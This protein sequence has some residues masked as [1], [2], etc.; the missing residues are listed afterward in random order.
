MRA[1]KNTRYGGP[2]VLSV[3]Q[4]ERPTI[5][6]KQ[7]L[8]EVHAA[9]VTQGDRRLR[10]ADFP[11]VLAIV[12]RLL[13]GVFRPR[14]NVGGTAFSGRVVEVG[15]EVSRLAVG[16]DVFG[17]V[18]QGAYAEYLAV[19]EKDAVAKMPAVDYAEAAALPYGGVTAVA[20][21]RDIAQVQPGER[22]LVVGATG[23]VGRLAVQVAKALGAHVTGVGSRGLEQVLELG[24]DEVVDYRA[25]PVTDSGERWDVVIDTHRYAFSEYRGVL[26]RAGRYVSVYV[27]PRLFL[28]KLIAAF[29]GGPRPLVGLALGSL[30]QLEKL[31]ELV[32]AGAVRESVAARYPF[33]RIVDAHLALDAGDVRGSVVVE[34][35]SRP[36]LRA[37]RA[38]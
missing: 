37:A 33:E 3:E 9:G 19:D 12:G 34:V 25:R 23:G 32:D 5:G 36:N 29:R 26:T 15:A 28:D 24:A 2:E 30:E 4:V 1:A 11:G 7:V 35:V 6:P 22:V 18:M 27:E 16:D 8:V 13:F 17:T 10:A 38:A 31:R 14:R 21:L 20:F